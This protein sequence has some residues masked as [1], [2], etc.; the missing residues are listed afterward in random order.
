[1]ACL[2]SAGL[3]ASLPSPDAKGQ[4]RPRV[5]EF[6]PVF[7]RFP[8]CKCSGKREDWLE[9]TK[10][11]LFPVKPYYMKLLLC[12]S[13]RES[14]L[15]FKRQRDP[16]VSTLDG[17]VRDLCSV[18]GSATDLLSNLLQITAPLC[19]SF[20]SHS[21]PAVSVF[22]RLSGAESTSHDVCVPC[23]AQWSLCLL[24]YTL[25]QQL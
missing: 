2:K 24:P 5:A 9:F 16:V 21:V 23:S 11:G 12:L 25:T 18:P 19:L 7:S 13:S 22:C 17:H 8:H 10:S 4:I 1:M 3:A 15:R 14:L 6:S 20:P